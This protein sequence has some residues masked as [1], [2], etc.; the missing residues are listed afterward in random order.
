[1][2]SQPASPASQVA[3]IA[4]R[5]L[6]SSGCIAAMASAVMPEPEPEPEP[7]SGAGW[8]LVRA[9]NAALISPATRTNDSR[10]RKRR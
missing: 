1:M 8:A 4:V 9:T 3:R 6:G 10:D 5:S 7:G 2:R